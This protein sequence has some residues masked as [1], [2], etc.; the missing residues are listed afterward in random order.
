LLFAGFF[1]WSLFL[2]LVLYDAVRNKLKLYRDEILY[3]LIWFVAIFVFF[4]LASSKLGSYIL[5]VFPA[6]SLLV[7]VFWQEFAITP[8][9]AYHKAVLLSFIPVATMF[10]VALIWLFICPP[11]D[12]ETKFGFN[13]DHLKYLAFLATGLS[14]LALFAL[15]NRRYPLFLVFT[16]SL[17]VSIVVI[18]IQFVMPAID[19]YR[20]T[21]GLAIKLDEILEP[22]ENLLFYGRAK[23]SALFYT[24]RKATRLNYQQL[25][26]LMNSN[27]TV[28]C[29]VS[30]DDWEEE[31]TGAEKFATIFLKDGDRLIITN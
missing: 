4:S 16:T 12:I 29:V 13:L 3:V 6:L 2:P 22:E 15:L 30:R 8:N 23:A 5:P 18:A 19:P 21:K 24:N 7:G 26:K 1:P 28:Y 20:S 10:L 9:R 17:M 27:K 14:I 11:F 25:R 31:L